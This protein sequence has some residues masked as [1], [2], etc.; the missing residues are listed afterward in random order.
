MTRARNCAI[1]CAM[2]PHKEASALVT[3]SGVAASQALVVVPGEGAA[4]KLADGSGAPRAVS[5]SKTIGFPYRKLACNS[6]SRLCS[7]AVSI[8]WPIRARAE[9][10]RGDQLAGRTNVILPG[11]LRTVRLSPGDCALTGGPR[12]TA[13]IAIAMRRVRIACL[14]MAGR[15][16]HAPVRRHPWR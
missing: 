2:L 5:C 15:Q 7:K 1:S 14:I 12:Q 16:L 11:R 4:L 10:L 6:V 13:K 9:S 3:W 8:T